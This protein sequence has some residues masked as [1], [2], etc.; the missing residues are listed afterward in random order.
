MLEL[1]KLP[2]FGGSVVGQHVSNAIRHVCPFGHS[3]DAVFFSRFYFIF[4]LCI[5][6]FIAQAVLFM[7][8]TLYMFWKAPIVEGV[9]DGSM[10]TAGVM[11]KPRVVEV[12]KYNH[13]EKSS[14]LLL[15]F[16]L[17]F[18]LLKHALKTC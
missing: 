11:L 8:M 9:L 17:L 3:V 10:D 2:T 15:P 18:L 12:R 13:G 5:L 6:P 1:G 16:E 14:Y 4:V 7:V